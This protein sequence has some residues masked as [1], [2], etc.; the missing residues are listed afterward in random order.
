MG[1][2]PNLAI[3]AVISAGA[4]DSHA[5]FYGDATVLSASTTGCNNMTTCPQPAA[6][7]LTGRTDEFAVF[8]RCW[9]WF[10]KALK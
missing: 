4:F 8:F 5:C 1:V 6:L 10:T 3:G 9:G 7:C 2:D